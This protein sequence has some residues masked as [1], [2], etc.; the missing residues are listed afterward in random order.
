MLVK[1]GICGAQPRAASLQ[2]PDRFDLKTDRRLSNSANS[3]NSANFASSANCARDEHHWLDH[4]LLS[5][6]GSR[7]GSLALRH[8]ARGESSKD[9]AE[10]RR[11]VASWLERQ[12]S[13]LNTK[14]A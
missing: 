2:K 13:R 5:I 12:Q 4:L 9:C 11:K 8:K 10:S 3:A 14:Q 1:P 6:L 7:F